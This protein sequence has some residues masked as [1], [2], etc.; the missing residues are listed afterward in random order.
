MN[1]P[2]PYSDPE[3]QLALIAAQSVLA[4]DSLIP[5]LQQQRTLNL[6][7]IRTPSCTDSEAAS[8]NRSCS[9]PT[10]YLVLLQRVETHVTSGIRNNQYRPVYS[11][12]EKRAV[13]RCAARSIHPGSVDHLLPIVALARAL[14]L[15]EAI[16]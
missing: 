14:A 2:S 7:P 16:L 13:W 10:G 12:P 3:H 9:L 4:H 6:H 11:I 1:E 15:T 8:A 5:V